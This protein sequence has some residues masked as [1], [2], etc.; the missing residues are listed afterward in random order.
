MIRRRDFLTLLGGVAVWPLAA[1]AQQSPVPVVG[2]LN[3]A[4]PEPYADR[5]HAFRQGLSETGYVEHRNVAIEYRWAEG[6]YDRLPAMAADLVRRQVAVIVVNTPAI[7]PAK[8][9]TTTIPIVFYTATDPVAGGFVS[10]LSR[11]GGNLTAVTSLNVLLVPKRV[12]LLHELTPT[13]RIMAALVNPTNPA[14][15]TQAKDLKAAAGDLGLSLEVVQASSEGDFD[16]VFGSLVKMRAGALVIAGDPVFTSHDAQLGA[17][18]LR[19]MMPAIYQTRGFTAGGGLMSYVGRNTDDYR[20]VGLYTGRILK[21]EKPPDLPVQQVAAV[22]LI[23][24]LKT[25]KALGLTVPPALVYRADE[26]I[27]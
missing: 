9:A 23:I 22:E 3:G 10:S 12:E 2:F 21:G 17:L 19:G 14:A 18:A 4:S 25:A 1:R 5:V 27:E 24:N 26:V 6:R 20:R 7:L 16:A 13:T 8:A 15:E 11:P